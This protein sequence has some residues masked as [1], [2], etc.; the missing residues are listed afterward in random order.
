MP[1]TIISNS[2]LEA[3]TMLNVVGKFC[4]RHVITS[5]DVHAGFVRIVPEQMKARVREIVDVEELTPRRAAPP[6]HNLRSACYFCLMK[7]AQQ[8]RRNMAA[9]RM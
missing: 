2:S 4:N 7:A 5:A 6:D 8:C 3:H 9:L 1:V